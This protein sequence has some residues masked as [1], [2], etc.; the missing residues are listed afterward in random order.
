MKSWFQV[1]VTGFITQG[2]W[3]LSAVDLLD[4]DYI[5]PEQSVLTE[6]QWIILDTISVSSCRSSVIFY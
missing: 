6:L 3:G 2:D 5:E 1:V 4:G